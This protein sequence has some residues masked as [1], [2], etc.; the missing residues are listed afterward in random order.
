MKL[1][2]LVLSITLLFQINAP[3]V[4]SVCPGNNE[5]FSKIRTPPTEEITTHVTTTPTLPNTT[6]C[7]TYA[8][9]DGPSV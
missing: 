5:I 4:E 9:W 7:E 1:T 2:I 8:H 6:T 3:V